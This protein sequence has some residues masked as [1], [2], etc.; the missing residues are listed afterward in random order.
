MK[1]SSNRLINLLKSL[2]RN[3]YHYV[4]PDTVKNFVPESKCY[5]GFVCPSDLIK[6]WWSAMPDSKKIHSS[7]DIYQFEMV[8]KLILK[9]LMQQRNS[10]DQERFFSRL[11]SADGPRKRSDTVLK[12][13]ILGV[14]GKNE[15]MFENDKDL[16]SR[17][18]ECYQEIQDLI[19]D[20][21]IA[22][23]LLSEDDQSDPSSQPSECISTSSDSINATF[24][25]PDAES[26]RNVEPL[27]QEGIN[28]A[29]FNEAV[30]KHSPQKSHKTSLKRQRS[31][32]D[33]S[34]NDPPAKQYKNLPKPTFKPTNADSTSENLTNENRY[35]FGKSILPLS[36]NQ[37]PVDD[38]TID[39]TNG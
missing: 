39:G 20:D 22:Q 18:Q 29:T 14:Y 23:E 17:F 25:I 34:E 12:A 19:L 11:H 27:N 1:I 10:S 30:L 5:S 4:E 32:D 13:V 28:N 15:K 6:F 7:D 24:G 2:K 31:I 21:Q 37:T 33:D 8:R 36:L 35:E 9:F 3:I 38:R 26:T 16:M